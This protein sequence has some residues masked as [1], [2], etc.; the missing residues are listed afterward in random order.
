M[1]TRNERRVMALRRSRLQRALERALAGDV[2]RALRQAARQAEILVEEGR[3]EEALNLIEDEVTAKIA[4]ALM[5]RLSVIGRVFV[6]QTI[7]EVTLPTKEEGPSS[8]GYAEFVK[9]LRLRALQQAKII[10]ASTR[11][12]VRA[13][14]L[15]GA[16][17]GLGARATAKLVN[18]AIGGD[19][20]RFAAERI[21][22]TEAHTAA[23]VGSHVAAE[24]TG[25][26]LEKVWAA[27]PDGRTR[28]SHSDADGQRRAMDEPFNIGGDLLMFPGDPDGTAA[29][30]INCR[31]VVMYE[32]VER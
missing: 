10:A 5:R 29:E 4:L 27:T 18:E 26:E 14:L 16:D 15:T 19:Y 30:V 11:K 12:K 9:W 32:P 8:Q 20:P 23:S 17:E 6:T 13:A 24:A 7:E 3:L 22:R 25:L 2:A 1:R 21:A 28:G 31:C